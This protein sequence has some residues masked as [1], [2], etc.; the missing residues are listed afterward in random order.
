MSVLANTVHSEA[1][2]RLSRQIANSAKRLE[3]LLELN[4]PSF[5]IEKERRLLAKRVAKFPT[6]MG[7]AE[8]N[9]LARGA[10]EQKE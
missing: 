6:A 10:A 3:R 4:A 7:I 1:L 8:Y 9:R 5:F 2:K